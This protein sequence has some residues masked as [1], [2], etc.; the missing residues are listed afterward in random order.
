MLHPRSISQS[1][2]GFLLTGVLVA[3]LQ[4]DA[5]KPSPSPAPE[6]APASIAILLD[7]SGSMRDK[8]N[9][10]V[11]ALKELVKASDPRDEFFVVNFND[12]P[13]LDADYTSD[14]KSIFKALD[15]ADARSGTSINDT[16]MAAIEH[17]NKGAKYKKRAIVLLT[18]GFDNMS[19]IPARTLL[20]ELHKP[21]VPVI[22]GIG[23][24]YRGKSARERKELDALARETGGKT[25]YPENETQL[26]NMARQVAREIGSQV[27]K[28]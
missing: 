27:M 7:N 25:F 4:Q 21:G 24:F 20:Q 14:T 19:R 3:P 13:Y 22:Y 12:S 15:R 28:E 1:F 2:L 16:M 18:D 17:F 23:L 26:N 6:D 11:A 9:V 5:Q 8:R 10:A